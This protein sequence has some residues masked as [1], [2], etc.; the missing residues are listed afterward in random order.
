MPPVHTVCE[1]NRRY[2]QTLESKQKNQAIQ[3][4]EQQTI[5]GESDLFTERPMTCHRLSGLKGYTAGRKLFNCS[6]VT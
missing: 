1:R 5:F 3:V 6:L 4:Y 2:F